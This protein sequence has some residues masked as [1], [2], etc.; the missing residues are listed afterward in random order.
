MIPD[1]NTAT[2]TLRDATHPDDPTA[3]DAWLA[4]GPCVQFSDAM[5]HIGHACDQ[6]LADARLITTRDLDG[7]LH[8]LVTD[9]HREK[10]AAVACRAIF[11]SHLAAAVG[12]MRALSQATDDMYMRKIA[13][14]LE[15]NAYHELMP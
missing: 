7:P 13:D 4:T 10:A 5:T 12:E 2:T 3:T 11:E 1:R 6:A 9:L 15:T 14:A 8:G